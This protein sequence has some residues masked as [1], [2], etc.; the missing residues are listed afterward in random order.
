MIY[1][2]AAECLGDDVLR[3][4]LP[5]E[6]GKAT[7]T[8]YGQAVVGFHVQCVFSCPTISDHTLLIRQL[9]LF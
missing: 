4:L 9:E 3:T 8:G 1:R 5:E 2:E 7:S 6:L